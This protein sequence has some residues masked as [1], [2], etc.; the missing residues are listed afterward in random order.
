MGTRRTLYGLKERP[1]LT[2]LL[3]QS[4]DAFAAM[5]PDEQEAEL[6]KQRQSWARQDKD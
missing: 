6:R 1:E 3:K 4:V 5:T 2:R